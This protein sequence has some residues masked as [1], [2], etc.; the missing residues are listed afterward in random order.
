MA[1]E[2]K[3][4]R[5]SDEALE[6]LVAMCAERLEREGPAAL[7]D[8]CRQHPQH[9]EV[10]RRR[11]KSLGQLCQPAEAH[12]QRVGPYQILEVLGEGGM[13][14]VFLAEQ[15]EPVRRRVALKLI[16]LGMDSKGVLARFDAERQ[17]LS[18]MEHSAIARVYDAGTS[19]RGQPYFAMEYVKG[20][21][22]TDY[23][24]QNKLT[25]NARIALFRQVCSGV[26]HAH[27]KG[28]MHRDLKPGN[29]LVTVQDG[30]PAPKIIDFGLAK[31]VDHRLVQ[32][33]LHTE[34]GMILG[35]PEYMSPE[36][37]G[38]SGLDV[39]T[40]TDVYSL[41]VLLYQLLTG[42]LPFALQELRQAGY[43]EMQ[44]V[45]RESDPPK[46][47]TRVTTLGEASGAAAQRRGIGSSELQ[48]ALR[49]ELDWIVMKAL[50]KDRTRRYET[51]LEFAADLERHLLHEPVL[52]GPPSASYRIAKF[53]QRYRLQVVAAGC[54]LI[55]M[56]AAI[57]GISWFAFDAR[58]QAE[59]ADRERSEA[60]RQE[61]IA[62]ANAAEA[63]AFAEQLQAKVHDYDLLSGTVLVRQLVSSEGS[64]WPALPEQVKPMQQ[65]IQRCDAMLAKRESVDAALRQLRAEAQPV[66]AAGLA[67][68][69][70][71]QPR[72]EEWARLCRRL[73]TLQRAAAVRS[74]TAR[75]Q[76]P[77]LPAETATLV[78][79]AL[80]ELAWQRVA[81][82]SS[83]RT[84]EGEHDLGLVYA[85]AALVRVDA[86]DASARRI[87][88]LDTLA[89]ALFANGR[90]DDARAR[91]AE[92]LAAAP[93]ADMES[94]KASQHQ[95]HKA[96]ADAEKPLRQQELQVAALAAE[97]GASPPL[98]FER[99]AHRFLFGALAG[100][101]LLLDDLEQDWRPSVARRLQWA[102]HVEDLTLHHPRAR[103]TWAAAAEA[104]AKADGITASARYR[105]GP[106]ALSPQLGLVP[107]GMNPKTKLWEFY[108]LRSAW[109]PASGIE[110]AA[111][112]E[113]PQHDPVTGNIVVG[114]ATGIVFVLLPGG[115]FTMGAQKLDPTAPNFDAEAEE[116]SPLNDV[117]L[118]PFFL[119]RHELTQGQW[120]R[121]ADGRN[122]SYFFAGKLIEGDGVM[123]LSNPVE[124]VSWTDGVGLLQSWSMQL[125]TE[126]QWE[127]AC[128]A[129]TTTTWWS[130]DGAAS[131]AGKA[132]V[133]D[134]KA[135]SFQPDW[136]PGEAFDDCFVSMAPVG[137]YAAN[138]FGLYDMH[139]NVGEWCRDQQC[140]YSAPPDP[141]DGG[142]SQADA[143]DQHCYRGGSFRERAGRASSARRNCLNPSTRY[144][145]IG[146][147][148]ARSLAQ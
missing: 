85:Q 2:R 62:S 46:P 148:A 73:M 7:D 63:K 122:P 26:Q 17:A 146:L 112:F 77:A 74:G 130:G 117:T 36:Q 10:I 101:A 61:G 120:L 72:A 81:P 68:L 21:P 136:V 119:A 59:A 24:D 31:A 1:E 103:V 5:L 97:L 53:A 60:R 80:N 105:Q 87:D 84:V 143:V 139:G 114:D 115:T 6:S 50:E 41:G 121:M 66:D 83:E 141:V 142:R 23:C 55:A 100:I 89:W 70:A 135:V 95:L 75:F 123:V 93:P 22:I 144:W 47:S 9:A 42:S 33:T 118:A 19:E 30:K 145:A 88:V 54:V 40:R 137:S 69:A 51:P 27:L 128:R 8:V 86:G 133:L 57:A 78:A 132:N 16:K 79:L 98:A 125:P 49:G 4:D 65:W 109:D 28:V 58:Q 147:R 64:L 45:I 12:P 124:Q 18:M 129:G 126:A 38:L 29:V 56:L 15:K 106:R 43:L 14:T 94:L 67:P 99:E 52:A 134:A 113:I 104:I 39:D 110:A 82:S 13:G 76:L 35:T 48:R 44:R 108:D 11:I 92:A 71:G 116:N 111:A 140:S 96:I 107:I 32:A 34:R 102:L 25:I 20:V 90:D 131:L 138:G 3:E 37:A 91:S 127:F